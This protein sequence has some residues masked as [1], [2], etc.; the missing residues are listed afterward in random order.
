MLKHF[1]TP[2]ARIG[3]DYELERVC[4]DGRPLPLAGKPMRVLLELLKSAPQPM[5]RNALI[6]DLWDR[7]FLTGEKGLT[8]ALWSI[9]VAIEAVDG[10]PKWIRTVARFGY[11][12]VGPSA[13]PVQQMPDLKNPSI[14]RSVL[15]GIAACATLLAVGT[16]GVYL[17]SS[18]SNRVQRIVAANGTIALM[19]HRAV[20]IA[21][22]Q[23]R[24]VNFLVEPPAVMRAAAFS[25]DGE[26]I[27][28][29][30]SNGNRCQMR[31]FEF[32]S[33]QMESYDTCAHQNG[34]SI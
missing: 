28:L 3:V 19:N 29:S 4:I 15:R 11:Q 8:Q 7:N 12:W 32:R 17:Q 33:Q 1:L 25:T 20:M 10:D 30:V 27:F 22:H 24:H 6:E 26:K 9:R 16:L 18:D 34:G 23:G 21:D 5:N 13:M 31:V 2:P 14:R